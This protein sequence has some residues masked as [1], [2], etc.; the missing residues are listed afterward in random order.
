[1]FVFMLNNYVLSMRALKHTAHLLLLL[2]PLHFIIDARN[3]CVMLIWVVINMEW[4]S[5]GIF[6]LIKGDI[7]NTWLIKCGDVVIDLG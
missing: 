4:Q 7:P 5:Y 3:K 2:R 6:W 1:M